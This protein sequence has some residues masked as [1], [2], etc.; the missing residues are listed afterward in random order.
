MEAVLRDQW[1][2]ERL[3]RRDRAFALA[4][5]VVLTALSWLYL[6]RMAGGMSA[7]GDVHMAMPSPRTWTLVDF[8][9]LFVMWA[10]MMVAMM[11]PSAAPMILLVAGVHRRRNQSGGASTAACFVLGY[12]VVWGLFS[13][14][15]ALA[16]SGLHRAA[17]LS[18]QMAGTSPMIGG[19]LL[20]AAGIYQWLPIKSACLSHC[21]SP[22]G[23]LTNHWR[24]GRVGGLLMG[25]RHGQ[26]CVGCCWVLML[27]LF[28]VGVMNLFWV[29]LLAAFTLAERLARRGVHLS[30][31]GGAALIAWGIWMMA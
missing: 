10:V 29:A 28:V 26:F 4:A 9:L 30:R 7:P 5:L 2:V 3:V 22:L 21:R 19:V 16:Q 15:A 12:F 27:L 1:A 14:A 18:P 24:E 20:A 25:M 11:L 6:V 13:A 31:I 23:F 8:L 17:L